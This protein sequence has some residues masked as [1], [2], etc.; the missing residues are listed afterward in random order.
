MHKHLLSPG[1][2]L[3]WCAIVA[4]LGR[5]DSSK[6]RSAFVRAR[7]P[8]IRPVF[9]SLAC[10]HSAAVGMFAA[11]P[12]A[13]PRCNLTSHVFMNYLQAN[14]L[15]S[16]SNFSSFAHNKSGATFTWRCFTIALG[17]RRYSLHIT[18]ELDFR[19][20]HC[21]M[22][23]PGTTLADLKRVT[24]HVQALAQCECGRAPEG[25]L[26]QSFAHGHCHRPLSSATALH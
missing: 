21:L 1:S 7:W 20:R 9:H 16:T 4:E 3:M 23:M 10:I 5:V 14:F 17:C 25:P 24:S 26:G 15:K 8:F 11:L 2:T 13:R 19:V 6:L 12:A 22:A 18:A